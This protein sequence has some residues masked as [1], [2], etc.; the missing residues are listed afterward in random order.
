MSLPEPGEN[1]AYLVEHV[2]LIGE[3]L[4][5]LTGK[6]FTDFGLNN[7]NLGKSLYHAPFVIV[8]KPLFVR[9]GNFCDFT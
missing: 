6:Q 2:T 5:R 1:N 9:I 4:Q 3:S 8:D 7:N